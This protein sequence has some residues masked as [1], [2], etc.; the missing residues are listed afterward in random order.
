MRLLRACG[1]RALIRDMAQYRLV[2]TEIKRGGARHAR[3]RRLCFDRLRHEHVPG[4]RRGI[5]Q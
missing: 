1:R 4:A 2:K 3:I 5:A